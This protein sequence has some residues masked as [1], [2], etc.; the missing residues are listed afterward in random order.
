MSIPLPAV[1]SSSISSEPKPVGVLLQQNKQYILCISKD[2]SDFDKALFKNVNL[3]EYEDD[4]HRNVPINSYPFDV[5]VL[6]MRQKT[7]RY[8]FMKEVQSNRQNYYV[9]MYCHSF[10][11]E[12]DHVEDADN[13]ISKLPE[14]QAKPE[15]F[16]ALLLLKRVKK[17]RWY[18]SLFFCFFKAYQKAKT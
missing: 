2:L 4:I 8:C 15:D 12:E 3:I 14:R 13:I 1:I 7:D 17:P 18:A 16:L 6:D 11:K 10:E 5:L 9:V